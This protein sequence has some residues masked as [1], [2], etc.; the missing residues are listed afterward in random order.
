MSKFTLLFGGLGTLL[1]STVLSCS[2]AEKGGPEVVSH[3]AER[4]ERLDSVS[5][6]K[7]DSVV[8]LKKLGQPTAQPATRRDDK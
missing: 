6:V 4:H 8:I 5:A 3:D 1:L 2:T 7:P